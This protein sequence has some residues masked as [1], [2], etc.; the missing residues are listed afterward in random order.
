MNL[1]KFEDK[2][3]ITRDSGGVKVD[4]FDNPINV[5]EIYND[6]C[7]YQQG[8]Q[9]YMGISVRNSLVFIP[10]RVKVEENDIVVVYVK[11]DAVKMQGVVTNP[12]YVELPLTGEKVTRIELSQ[13]KEVLKDGDGDGSDE[14]ENEDSEDAGQNDGNLNE[15]D[16]G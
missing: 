11:E 5:K 9:A 13:V 12:R 7:R 16:G 4:E 10:N 3:V 1:I 14:A 8:V 6:K 15:G 2:C